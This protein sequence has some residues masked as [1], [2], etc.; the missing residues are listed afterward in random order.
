[1]TESGGQISLKSASRTGDRSFRVPWIRKNWQHLALWFIVILALAL[2]IYQLGHT[3]F[4]GSE[5]HTFRDATSDPGDVFIT[6]NA[7]MNSFRPVYYILL[8]PWMR[9]FGQSESAIRLLSVIAGIASLPLLFYVCRRWFAT[10]TALLCVLL[11][12]I[13]IWHIYESRQ[14]RMYTLYLF[15]SIASFGSFLSL[16]GCPGK[17]NRALYILST[18]AMGLTHAHG[19][20]VWFSQLLSSIF[21]G[22]KKARRALFG[23]HLLI[24]PVVV[25]LLVLSIH[26]KSEIDPI[27]R[28]LERPQYQLI[29]DT[30][31]GMSQNEFNR[32]A[33]RQVWARI[34]EEYQEGTVKA[35]K[36]IYRDIFLL[37]FIALMCIGFAGISRSSDE[38]DRS[39]RPE[40]PGR[41]LR[42]VLGSWIA[43]SILLPFYISRWVTPIT[44]ARFAFAAIVP[45]YIAISR[46]VLVSGRRITRWCLVSLIFIL[47]IF[48]NIM[49]FQSEPTEHWR[50]FLSEV[51]REARPGDVVVLDA[52][53]AE[54]Q[55]RYYYTGPDMKM[56]QIRFDRRFGE[57]DVPGL[58]KAIDGFDRVWYVRYH[59]RDPE[60]LILRTLKRETETTEFSLRDRYIDIRLFR[61]SPE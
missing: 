31:S 50:S 21:R 1:V 48:F 47:S 24:L 36:I 41:Y 23:M 58:Q 33:T 38:L 29:V 40:L 2:R 6:I 57:S 43:C 3:P 19:F 15:F 10:K 59:S 30:L 28:H 4:Q 34:G 17:R 52:G 55:M 18:L 49:Y 8:L 44:S 26:W 61:R 16:S 45:F 56:V 53:F 12:S 14:A 22:D 42:W 37:A 9:A 25:V 46:G 5:F 11:L 20:F 32:Y 60:K 7:V 35:L 39:K 54:A 27:V 51:S 13:S